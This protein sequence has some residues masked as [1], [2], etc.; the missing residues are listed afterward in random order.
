MAAREASPVLEAFGNAKTIRNDN[1]SRFGKYVAVQYGRDG[2]IVGATTETYLLER[3]C[4]WLNNSYGDPCPAYTIHLNSNKEAALREQIVG[5]AP[6]P[7]AGGFNVAERGHP[8]AWKE[9]KPIGWLQRFMEDI[10]AS[11]VIDL[12]PGSG[13]LARACLE[14][15]IQYVGF[16]REPAHCSWLINV[17]N[18]AAVECTTR[19]GSTLYEQDLATCLEDHFK[20]LIEELQDQDLSVS[21][22]EE[23][24]A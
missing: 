5:A 9:Q 6:S 8:F 24:L 17:L 22:D 7:A 23:G 16:T 10:S 11:L 3:A 13:A 12:T 4:P 15:G 19:N 2:G 20:E 14:K 1:S 21:D 18:R